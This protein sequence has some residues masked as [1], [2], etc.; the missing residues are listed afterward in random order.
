MARTNYSCG[1][2][3][4]THTTRVVVIG[5][6]KEDGSPYTLALGQAS[7]KGM[8]LGYITNIDQ[9]ASSIKEAV[10][11]AEK[12]LG[13]KIKRA[14]VS[15]GG[16]SLGSIVLNGSVIISRADQ[17]ITRLDISK[18]LTDSEENLEILNKKIIHIIP[19]GYKLDGKDIHG[20]P[21]GMKGVKLEVKTLFITCLKQNIEDLVSALATAG[22]E[23][24]DV[25]ASPIASATILLTA[26]QKT[27]GCALVDIGAETVSVAVFENGLLMSL[28]VFSI[29]SMDITKD[30][31]LGF[32]IALE[33]AE[34]IKLGSVI[35]GDYPKKKIDEIIEARL[36]DIF[37]LVGNH[38]KRQRRSE[39]LPAGIIITGGGAHIGRI[40]ELA[41]N[42]LKLPCRV[43]PVDNLIN[44]KLKIRDWSWYTAFG[45]ALSQNNEENTNLNVDN[46]FGDNIKQ[47][48]EFLKQLLKQLLP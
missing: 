30:V 23:A 39:L 34:S 48:K 47:V 29:G 27:A 28:Q 3:V 46:S 22:I 42:Q 40:E 15:I 20:R 16:I 41:K 31:A 26:K 37:E 35:G 14:Y 13:S 1:I 9:V 24:Q 6:S 8:R 5:Y 38:L 33:E 43:G 10:G 7:T 21:E 4:G 2:D 19:I 18:A 11:Q 45:L 36:S 17:E 25:I 12:I 44:N 32:R